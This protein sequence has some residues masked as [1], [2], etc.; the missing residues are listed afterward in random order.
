MDPT[1]RAKLVAFYE[2]ELA[3]YGPRDPRSLHWINAHTQRVRFQALYNVG[4][5]KDVSVAD[6]GCGLG[7]FCGFLTEQGHQVVPLD[8]LRGSEEA[9][10]APVRTPHIGLIRYVGYDLSPKMAQ[11]ARSNYPQGAFKVRDILEEGL[12]QP[13]DYVVASGTLNIRVADHERLFREMV[14]SMYQGCT[15][16]VAFNFLGPENAG[17]YGASRYYGADPQEIMD[18]CTMLCRRAT[19]VQGYLANDYTVYM[20]RKV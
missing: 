9:V 20:Y 3:R 5:W 16:S 10:S 11:A 2:S 6:I 1:E 12:E 13:C 15:R 4:M 18:Y 7:D 14:L 17:S 19:L 8:G